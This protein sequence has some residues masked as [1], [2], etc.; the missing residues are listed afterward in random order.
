[1]AP[2]YFES[3]A[4]IKRYVRET[5]TAWVLGVVD[6]SAGNR[7]HVAL[8]TGVEVVSALTRHRRGGS[9]SV[10]GYT[11]ALASFRQDFAHAYRKTAVTPPLVARAMSLA[12]THALRGYDAVQLAAALRVQA[13]RVA[14]GRSVLTFVSA[15]AA[16]NAAAVA[17]GL[18]VDDPNNHP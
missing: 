16:L 6:P 3:S 11:T 5:G 14:R 9:L 4:L 15:D 2:Y 8:I 7:I 12:E 13:L 1:V 17:E 18:L 10:A